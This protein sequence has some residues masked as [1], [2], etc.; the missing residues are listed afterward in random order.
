M[1]KPLITRRLRIGMA[2]INVTVGD[3]AGN[4]HKIIAVIEEAKSSGVD[5]LTF[6]ELAICGYPPED[7]LFKPRFIAENL[8]S[9]KKVIEA[10][11]GIT[12]VVG[13]VDAKHDIYNAAAVIHDGKL[14][15]KYYKTCLSNYGVLDDRRYFRA[16]ERSP[17]Y[18][19]GRVKISITIGEEIR[20]E[21]GSGADIIVNMS[22][23][24][25]YTGKA[26]ERERVF[27]AQAKGNKAIF[28]FCNPAGGQDELVFDGN[29]LI[30]DEKGQPI[31]RGKQFQEDLII[32]DL[33]IKIPG[34][35]RPKAT[36]T[37]VITKTL[38]GAAKPALPPRR[39]KVADTVAEIYEAL[40]LGTRDYV[41]KNGFKKVVIGLSGG[42]D[43][44]LVATIA[45][46]ALG[47]AN[48]NGVALPSRYSSP[49]SLA[50]ARLLSKNL[51]IKLYNIP[52]EK[53]FKAHL[54]TLA[55]PFKGTKTDITEENLQAR[56][57]SNLWMALSNKFGWLVLT[58]SNK[59]ECATGYA[60]LYG[61][62]AGG[63]AII[64]DIYKTMVYKLAAYRNKKAGK[65]LIPD[66]IINKPPSAELRPNQKDTDSLPPYE[67]LDPILTAYVEENKSI[68]QITAMGF[69]EKTV[70]R[71]AR[72][73]DT[74]EYKR[75]QGPPGIKITPR[76][77]GRDIRMPIT[78]RFR[79]E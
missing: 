30:I 76:A 27:A 24:P 16:G 65:K 15:D 63:F 13:F 66:T 69:N 71:V 68:G 48:V 75:R 21:N 26:A 10:S 11:K 33:N 14:I 50:D 18:T 62:M 19:I 67:V 25:Y 56:I 60:T 29:S 78:N 44:A 45:V 6:P 1:T 40:V 43:S 36:E 70:R 51:G 73:V 7:L 59:S 41:R 4:R 8:K 9:L 64:K 61:D 58:G 53:A 54:E 3:F 23:S 17:V 74:S 72:L 39:V 35:H 52:I 32:A 49:G 47:K 5:I 55:E 57:R 79:D 31:A 2:Q 42:I 77:F 22:A 37:I 12:L 20:H 34:V 46:D 28:A 38:S